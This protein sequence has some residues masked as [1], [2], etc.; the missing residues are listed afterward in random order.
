MKT[1]KN[2]KHWRLTK[3]TKY[4]FFVGDVKGELKKLRGFYNRVIRNNSIPE[5][6]DIHVS[7][8]ICCPIPPNQEQ[9]AAKARGE[10]FIPKSFSL[11]LNVRTQ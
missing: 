2:H 1:K 8:Q 9:L 5:N 11:H 7:R 10:E 6:I 3:R 4:N